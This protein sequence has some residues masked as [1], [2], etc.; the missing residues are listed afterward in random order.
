MSWKSIAIS[1]GLLLT[2][3]GV[4]E[5]G[6]AQ[7]KFQCTYTRSHELIVSFHPSLT[8]NFRAKIHNQKR[9]TQLTP[10]PRLSAHP[11]RRVFPRSFSKL[12]GMETSS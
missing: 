7:G 11:D 5:V 4:E 2:G 9:K 8:A 1:L 12:S 3:L 6:S 10:L